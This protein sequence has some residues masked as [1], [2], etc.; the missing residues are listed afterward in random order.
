MMSSCQ[1]MAFQFKMNN[2]TANEKIYVIDIETNGLYDKVEEI[3][4]IVIY[5]VQGKQ[6]FTYGPDAIADGLQH[7]AKA[8][9]LIGHN[10]IFYDIP[11]IRKLY[12]FYTF[13]AARLIDTLVCTRLIWPREV[14]YDLDLS[15]YP[16]V[17]IKLRGSASLKAWGYRLSDNKI[18]FKDFSAYSEEMAEYCRQDVSVTYK[19]FNFIQ[20]K[21]YPESSLKLEHEFAEAIND[22]II[23]GFPFDVDKALD[24]VDT[25]RQRQEEL[26]EEL[27]K[28]FPPI[29]E[30]SVFTPK[31]NNKKR[32]YVA[33]VPFTKQIENIFNPGSRKQVVERLH[34]KYGWQPDKTTDKGNASLDDDV[35]EALPFPEAKLLAEYQLIKKRLGQI[36]D[37]ENAWL[38][39]VSNEDNKMHGSMNTNG[40]VTGRCSHSSPNMA[41]VPGAY[42]PYGKECRDLFHAP[43]GYA[44]IGVDAKALE[45][46]C[47]AGYL[48]CWDN[49]EYGNM[50]INPDVDIHTYNQEQFG[51]STRDISKRLLYGLLY[52]C[53]GVKAGTIIDPNEK[54]V[55]VLKDI[56][57]TA[58]NSFMNGVPAL[59]LLKQQI[60]D[61][62]DTRG[63]LIGLDRR[64]LYC[65]SAFKGLNV[66]LQ[67]AGAILMKQVVVN[68]HNN[69]N[70]IDLFY[71]K[72]WMQLAMVH[73]EVQLACLPEHV[74]KV[75]E[76]ALA[77]FPQAQETF[78]FRC[79]IE[80]DAKVG[81]TWLDCH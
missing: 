78:N 44:L 50:V 31:V 79:L 63:Y 47:L 15:V 16:E 60:Q 1:S 64:Q 7:M 59:K 53:G 11:V 48:A 8:N 38:K 4:C 42:S 57:S 12:P 51:V 22:Q 62:I 54:D 40:C 69:L 76:Q 56:G 34:T 28:A 17:P 30:E 49:G 45:L 33:G 6:T 3:F 5:D 27:Q 81:Y 68:I 36:A 20:S 73:D 35:L 37:G 58:I 14:L 74:E 52:G 67:S 23:T 61:N 10:L 21:N 46:R 19:L 71:D 66:L 2:F 72:D 75:K 77:A 70:N 65:R 26:E 9:V 18:E 80:G 25:L 39:L 43:K 41:Q 32:G 55:T 29:T 24:L 13:R